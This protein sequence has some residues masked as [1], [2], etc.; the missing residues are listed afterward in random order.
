MTRRDCSACGGAGWLDDQRPHPMRTDNNDCQYCQGRGWIDEP[1]KQ[2]TDLFAGRHLRDQALGLLAESELRSQ[3][4]KEGC[5][6]AIQIA[7]SKGRVTSDDVRKAHP[8]PGDW[9]PRILGAV[10]ASRRKDF[11]LRKVGYTQSTFKQAHA[12]PIPVWTLK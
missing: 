4:I 12:R 2:Q 1:D 8:I 9:D 3:W 11:P 10:F 6:V 5:R 7:R